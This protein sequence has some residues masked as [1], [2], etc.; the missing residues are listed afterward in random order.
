MTYDDAE[1]IFHETQQIQEHLLQ[2]DAAV[3][4]LLDKVAKLEAGLAA[5]RSKAR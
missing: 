1:A 5:A 2:Q 3:N 4:A